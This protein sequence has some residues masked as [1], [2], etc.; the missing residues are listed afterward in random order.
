ME[1]VLVCVILCN[2]L[3]LVFNWIDMM[4]VCSGVDESCL[5]VVLFEGVD[6]GQ[7]VDFVVCLCVGFV[8]IGGVELVGI[9]N[10]VLFM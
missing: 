10:V 2:V 4:C 8:G 6:K 7:V 9:G 5:V 1:I 3:F